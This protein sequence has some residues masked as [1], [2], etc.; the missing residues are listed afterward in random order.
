YCG[1]L[2]ELIKGLSVVD[3]VRNL[4][5][6]LYQ[7]GKQL[8]H[9][10]PPGRWL[11]PESS[12]DYG[13]RRIFCNQGGLME[14]LD[15]YSGWGNDVLYRMCSERPNHTDVDTVSSKLWLIGRAYSASIER[16][17]GKDFNINDAAKIVIDR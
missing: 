17:A 9:S 7:A 10:S 13:S 5:Y 2:G 12:H 8:L 15:D 16:K 14:F 3:L 4:G 1:D 11:E 6:V